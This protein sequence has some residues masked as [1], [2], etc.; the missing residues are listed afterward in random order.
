[1]SKAKIESILREA[2][3]PVFLQVTDESHLHAG[4]SGAKSGGH[5]SV[6]IASAMFNGK[7]SLDCHRLIYKALLPIKDSIHALS[8]QSRGA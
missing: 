3:A 8:I 5:F 4:H 6:E 2:F 1:M 7:K